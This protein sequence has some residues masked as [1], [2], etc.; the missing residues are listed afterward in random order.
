[1]REPRSW[2]KAHLRECIILAGPVWAACENANVHVGFKKQFETKVLTNEIKH[3]NHEN[4]KNEWL[5]LMMQTTRQMISCSSRKSTP[6]L[7]GKK[8]VLELSSENVK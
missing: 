4:V 7:E 8:G 2:L 5:T 1:V 3:L 6:N